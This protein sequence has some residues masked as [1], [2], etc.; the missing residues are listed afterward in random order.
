MQKLA[1]HL[2]YQIAVF[3]VVMSKSNL[4]YAIICNLINIITG[5]SLLIDGSTDLFLMILKCLPQ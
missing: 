3:F 2:I 5:L 4:A 1:L